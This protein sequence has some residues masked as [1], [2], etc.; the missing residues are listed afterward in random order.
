MAFIVMSCVATII[1]ELV[2]DTDGIIAGFITTKQVVSAVVIIVSAV[3]YLAK[4]RGSRGIANSSVAS[5]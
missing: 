1:V 2:E 3:V 5:P 4:L